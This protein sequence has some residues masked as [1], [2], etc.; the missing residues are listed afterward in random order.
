MTQLRGALSAA[1]SG[2]LRQDAWMRTRYISVDDLWTL[3]IASQLPSAMRAADALDVTSAEL[4]PVHG[5]TVDL[6]A[7]QVRLARADRGEGPR[8]FDL[9]E[10]VDA[11]R[12]P[13]AEPESASVT[14]DGIHF[15]VLF[16]ANDVVAVT[17]VEQV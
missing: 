17:A 4:I 9:G 8:T 7:Y 15:I 12:R 2:V 3:L 1:E 5:G 13:L 16:D 6:H 14:A 11:L 10:F